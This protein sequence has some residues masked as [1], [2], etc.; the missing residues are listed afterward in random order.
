MRLLWQQKKHH[1]VWPWHSTA[2][3]CRYLCCVA[4]NRYGESNENIQAGNLQFYQE[5]I[6]C[7][8]LTLPQSSHLE[9]TTAVFCVQNWGG[10]CIWMLSAGFSSSTKMICRNA[11]ATCREGHVRIITIRCVWLAHQFCH[12]P[13]TDGTSWRRIHVSN[14]TWA[15]LSC[16][17]RKVRPVLCSVLAI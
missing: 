5:L 12:T 7:L 15:N 10:I 4:I 11:K 13:H 9:I 6:Q 16:Q 2:L 3:F 8:H 14:T 17:D 1:E